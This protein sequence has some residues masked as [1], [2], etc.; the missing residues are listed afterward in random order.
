MICVKIW[1][2][3]IMP[4][5]FPHL[6]LGAPV[7]EEAP[8]IVTDLRTRWF[9]IILFALLTGLC[10]PR[11]VRTSAWTSHLRVHALYFWLEHHLGVH[12]LIIIIYEKHLL[13]SRS[14][15]WRLVRRVLSGGLFFLFGSC[16][17]MR[18]HTLTLELVIIHCCH[19]AIHH[20]W[21]PALIKSWL[22][23]P[24]ILGEEKSWIELLRLKEIHLMQVHQMR[25]VL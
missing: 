2:L 19:A 14:S 4:T 7:V 16:L 20:L 15:H 18:A 9:G 22:S 12:S 23:C 10:G 8:P 24:S 17:F 13:F 5:D 3:L 21:L 25:I 1:L 11:G 6:L